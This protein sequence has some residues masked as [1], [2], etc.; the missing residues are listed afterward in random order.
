MVV[1][2][3]LLDNLDALAGGSA[4]GREAM[5][6][7]DLAAVAL[8]ESRLIIN[9][10]ERT[11]LRGLIAEAKE[12]AELPEDVVSEEVYAE[13]YYAFRAWLEDWSSTARALTGNKRIRARLG[14][15]NPRRKKCSG[16]AAV[17][18]DSEVSPSPAS[19]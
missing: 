17:T 1:V 11:R 16:D 10:D 5:R 6:E 19:G 13:K 18:E 15:Y 14:L 12:L 3:T 2:E 4:P 9:D 8:L 7:E